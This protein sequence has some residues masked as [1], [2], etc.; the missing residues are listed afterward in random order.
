MFS[1]GRRCRNQKDTLPTRNKHFFRIYCFDLVR[2]DVVSIF[3]RL[4]FLACLVAVPLS[5]YD[6]PNLGLS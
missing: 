5:S 1:N 4:L 2:F 6:C 3:F